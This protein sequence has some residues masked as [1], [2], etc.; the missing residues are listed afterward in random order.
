MENNEVTTFDKRD[1]L[2]HYLIGLAISTGVTIVLV[3]AMIG[4]MVLVGHKFPEDGL[5]IW[6]NAL[7]VAGGIMICSY[8]L[9]LLADAGTFDMLS[10]AVKLFWYNTFNKEVRKTKLAP[11]FADY[12]EEK[13][14]KKR[15][16]S[17]S[18]LL[19]PGIL[20]LAIG[21][22]LLIPFYQNM[23]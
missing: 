4:L 19:I 3:G 21:L 1:K 14:G 9:V 13:R 11:T 7:T 23:K 12:R 2:K 5:L 8:F 17:V 10:Y 15:T 16:N 22:L 20:V 6:I 18:F